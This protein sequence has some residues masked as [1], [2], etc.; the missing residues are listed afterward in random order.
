MCVHMHMC[1]HVHAE[2][3]RMGDATRLQWIMMSVVICEA[4]GANRRR[5]ELI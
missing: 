3:G 4:Q 2:G 5:P 1:A